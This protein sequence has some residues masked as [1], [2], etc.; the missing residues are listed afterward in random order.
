V[1]DERN[2]A[3]QRDHAG[4]ALLQLGAFAASERMLV[5]AIA[6]AERLGLAT[7][8]NDAK[9]HLGQF[10][11]RSFRTE[12]SVRTLSEAMDGFVAQQDP[13][14]EGLARIYRAGSIHLSREH[15]AAAEEA[16]LALPLLEGAPPYRAAALGLI[17]LMRIDAG[18][19]EGAYQAGVEAMRLLEACGGTVEGEAI[20]RIG[21][22]E[23]LRA[24]GDLAAS[25]VAIAAARD[26][27]LARAAKIKSLELRRGF[28]ERLQ[29]HGRILMR[30]GEWLA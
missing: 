30:A 5:D 1:G 19:A 25:R 2:A 10:Y 15:A 7:V 27:L 14:G 21:H 23:G 26:H 18:D 6:S 20:I 16:K 13:I 4:F 17:A 11:S 29:E 9:L 3:M 28:M 12:E 24:R 22:A 8:L